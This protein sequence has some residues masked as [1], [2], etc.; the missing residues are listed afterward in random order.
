MERQQWKCSPDS[1]TANFTAS[2]D[3][4][5]VLRPCAHFNME[6][7]APWFSLQDE[8]PAY[9]GNPTPEIWS[10]LAQRTGD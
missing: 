7:K 3:D 10:E 4:E 1:K 2:L 5:S 9:P 6:S 8:L